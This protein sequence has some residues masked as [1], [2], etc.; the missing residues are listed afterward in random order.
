M[1]SDSYTVTGPDG[2]SVDLPQVQ[3]TM[4]PPAVDVRKLYANTGGFTFDPGFTS[5][6]SCE[7]GITSVSYTHLTLPTKA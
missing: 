7:S 1:S 3:G 2:S 5:T 6:C 4:G